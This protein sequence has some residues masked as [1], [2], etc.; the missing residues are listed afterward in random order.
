M[1]KTITLLKRLVDNVSN[2]NRSNYYLHQIIIGQLLSDGNLI[3]RSITAN[4][5]FRVSCGRPFEKYANWLRE[6]FEKYIKKGV[7]KRKDRNYDR[8]D[9]ITGVNK[10]FNYYYNLFYYYNVELKKYVK[11]VPVN[12]NEIITPVVLA[13]L[14]IGDGTWNQANNI[15]KIATHGFTYQDCILLAERI[16][17]IGI[18]TTV[19][20]D[21][22]GSNGTQQYY[23]RIASRNNNVKNLRELVIP[24]IFEGILY[25]LG[26]RNKPL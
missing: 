23:L 21:Q 16:T 5:Y 19:N 24:H 26:I 20:K 17:K 11:I 15:V 6:F 14:I 10:N 1:K 8:Y 18:K 2:F 13:H 22:K 12:I 25:K 7:I 4:T 3:R 9:I